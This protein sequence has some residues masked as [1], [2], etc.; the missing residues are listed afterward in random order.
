ME[1]SRRAAADLHVALAPAPGAA[2]PGHEPAA[3]L[4]D[5]EIAAEPFRQ[6]C[7]IELSGVRAERID[8]FVGGVQLPAG[9]EIRLESG[10][11]AHGRMLART[12]QELKP[13]GFVRG[14]GYGP[15]EH[16]EK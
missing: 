2:K 10:H 13:L 5:I 12:E 15:S 16:F 1:S 3:A 6:C 9:I 8:Q 7:D 14:T 11:D 4:N